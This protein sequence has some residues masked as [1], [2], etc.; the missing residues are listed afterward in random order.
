MPNG[1]SQETTSMSSICYSLGVLSSSVKSLQEEVKKQS[2]QLENLGKVVASTHCIKEAE[3]S[4]M[5]EDIEKNTELRNKMLGGKALLAFLIIITLS[6]I[7]I[8]A[9]V[10]IQYKS[11]ERL[12]KVERLVKKVNTQENK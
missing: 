1:D 2:R 8:L 11:E 7:S 6:I 3:L 10:F 4:E 9:T 5:R 12:S